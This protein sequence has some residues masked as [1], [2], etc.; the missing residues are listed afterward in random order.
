LEDVPTSIKEALSGPDADKWRTAIKSEMRS[1]FRNHTWD[2]VK[3]P[4]GKNIVSSKWLFKIKDDDRF[5]ARMV[6]RG[7]SQTYGLDYFET[8]A[9]V[10]R[11]ASIRLL[12]ALAAKFGLKIQQMDV[13]TAFLYGD[14][15][16]EVFMEQPE[17][18][19]EDPEL[20]CRL[21]KSLYGLKQA[22]R[23]WYQVIDEFFDSIGLVRSEADPAVYIEK[24]PDIGNL[25]LMVAIY[26]DD[27]IIVH[28][29]MER[30]DKIKEA[31]NTK[32]NMKDMGDVQKLLGMEV[33]RLADGSI[34]INQPRYIEK[35]LKRFGMEGCKPAD[36]P[37]SLKI[38]GSDKDF[39]Q[40]IYQ[41]L[42]GGLTWPSLCTR[43]DISFAVGYLARWNSRPTEAHHTAQKRV[44][45]YL[46][47]TKYH[48][49]LFRAYPET[50]LVGFSDADWA[51]DTADRKSTSGNC[52]TLYDGAIVWAAVKQKTVATSTV[53]AEYVAVALTVKEAL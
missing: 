46:K 8:Y 27:L 45:R 51:G 4:Q 1:L 30:I 39:D 9:P 35:L 26:V 44:L 38:A 31:L 13:D 33:H 17:G 28:K 49:I 32:F 21:R 53:E 5:K 29:D 2:L 52:F 11:F 18:Y 41:S 12:L 14:L 7:F 48:G 6:A 25:P 47:G 16:E 10:A 23:V 43:P 22:P 40:V 15:D 36:T 37:M 3:R 24:D 42:T 34:F 19:I 20:V 50:R